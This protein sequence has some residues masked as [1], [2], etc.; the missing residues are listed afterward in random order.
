MFVHN[1]KTVHDKKTKPDMEMRLLS[2]MA[3]EKLNDEERDHH[4]KVATLANQIQTN[5]SN[6]S[7]VKQLSNELTS[8]NIHPGVNKMMITSS[9]NA[10]KR[11]EARQKI[12]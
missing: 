8:T 6:P 9:N 4:W 5:G 11:I 12:K 7:L 3:L 1:H 2:A 10:K